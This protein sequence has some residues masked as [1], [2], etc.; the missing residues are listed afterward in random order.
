[1]DGNYS[2]DLVLTPT[3][4]KNRFTVILYLDDVVVSRALTTDTSVKS[5]L[6]TVEHLTDLEIARQLVINPNRPQ[7]DTP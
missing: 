4:G 5:V 6:R 2:W 3:H 1:M 7:E